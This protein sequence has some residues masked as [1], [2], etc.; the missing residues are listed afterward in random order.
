MLKT[1][2]TEQRLERNSVVTYPGNVFTLA[3][4]VEMYRRL[5]KKGQTPT[6][7]RLSVEGRYSGMTVEQRQRLH[8]LLSEFES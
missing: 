1:I 8:K 6:L 7:A 3:A 2:A 4:A 5:R